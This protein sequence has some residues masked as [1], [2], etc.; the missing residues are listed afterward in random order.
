MA[1]GNFLASF[2]NDA[3]MGLPET[4]GGLALQTMADGAVLR[5]Q[6]RF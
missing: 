2:I 5:W 3:F 4:P 1:L 6:A